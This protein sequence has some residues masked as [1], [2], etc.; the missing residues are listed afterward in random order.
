[1]HLA[2][3]LAGATL[4][5]A[6]TVAVMLLYQAQYGRHRRLVMWSNLAAISIMVRGEGIGTKRRGNQC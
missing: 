6:A 1:V 4:L 2:L 3:C 5:V